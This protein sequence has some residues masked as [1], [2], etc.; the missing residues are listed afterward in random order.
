MT[1]RGMTLLRLFERPVILRNGVNLLTGVEFQESYELPSLIESAAI[2]RCWYR[3][4]W[5]RDG[6]TIEETKQ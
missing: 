5:E 3:E 2:G 6:W 1:D 4:V